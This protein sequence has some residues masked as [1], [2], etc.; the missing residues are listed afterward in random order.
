MLQYAECV[1]CRRRFILNYFG[2]DFDITNC[3][4]CD[5]CLR[6]TARAADLPAIGASTG[7]YKIA[8]VV[9]HPKFG[10]GTVERAEKDLVTVL[11]PNVGYKTLLATAVTRG[12]AA[13]I[14]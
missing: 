3:G 6:N 1:P 14:A 4:K 2:E 5:N 8:D 13:K 11:F 10:V 12:E 9:S 7:G